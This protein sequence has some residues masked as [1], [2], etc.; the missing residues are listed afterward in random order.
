M[1]PNQC[2]CLG[3]SCVAMPDCL[4]GADVFYMRDCQRLLSWMGEGL[5]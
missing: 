3:L 2:T 1:E 4:A 5:C